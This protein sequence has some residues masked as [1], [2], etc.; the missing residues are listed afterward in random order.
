MKVSLYLTKDGRSPYQDWLRSLRDEE[1]RARIRVR[2]DRVIAGNMGDAHAVGGGVSELG[3][4]YG[5]G[6]RVYFGRYGEELV[7]LLCGGEKNNQERDIALAQAYWE[8]CRR[9]KAWTR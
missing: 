2:I 1:A 7:I 5:P 3:V 6:Y 4:H 9:R 8:D